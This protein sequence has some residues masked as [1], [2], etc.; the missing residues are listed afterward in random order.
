M[1]L[2]NDVLAEGCNGL[3]KVDP[4]VLHEVEAEGVA[5]CSLVLRCVMGRGAPHQ[6][7]GIPP[8]QAAYLAVE[9][10]L[11]GLPLLL[12]EVL[13]KISQGGLNGI[14]CLLKLVGNLFQCLAN[15]LVL[16]SGRCGHTCMEEARHAAA[17]PRRL[18]SRLVGGFPGGL[19][20]GLALLGLLR[21][22]PQVCGPLP[23]LVDLLWR[24]HGDTVGILQRRSG[25]EQQHL[26]AHAAAQLLLLLR[27][28]LRG[29]LNTAHGKREQG[30]AR[31]TGWSVDA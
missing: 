1:S 16:D 19:L 10:L 7:H 6:V 9:G 30:S 25:A 29:S 21:L 27:G 24:S 28:A 20:H 17:S 5:L 12:H 8:L 23:E 3:L 15:Y 22:L 2:L 4:A 18:R 13:A 14:D 26:P 11:D 31:M